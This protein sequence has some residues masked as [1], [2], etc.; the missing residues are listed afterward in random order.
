MNATVRSYVEFSGNICLLIA[1]F[2]KIISMQSHALYYKESGAVSASAIASTLALGLVA[3]ALLGFIYGIV[4]Y[5]IPFIYLNAILAFFFG[6]GLGLALAM[7]ARWTKIRN[8]AAFIAIST[9][10]GLGGVYFAWVA[11]I[12]AVTEFEMLLWN[13]LAILEIQQLIMMT[14]A[15][16]IFGQTMQGMPLMLVWLIEAVLIAGNTVRTA[17]QGMGRTPFCE[18]C[19]RWTE[20]GI[21]RDGLFPVYNADDLRRD[22]EQEQ[23]TELDRLAA[24]QPSG[25]SFTRLELARCATCINASYLTVS[26]I[27]LEGNGDDIREKATVLIDNL[28]ISNGFQ[29]ELIRWANDQDSASADGFHFNSPEA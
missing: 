29:H 7:V 2:K 16:E 18:S 13:P 23:L 11:W 6:L 28:K 10:I 19:E 4:T 14:G 17:I 5:Y 27:T 9:V 21:L 8:R 22:L 1:N 24:S 25:N 12:Y 3:A 26:K 15:W 20:E